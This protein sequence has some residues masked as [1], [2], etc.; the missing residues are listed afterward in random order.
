MKSHPAQVGKL[1]EDA[2]SQTKGRKP[3]SSEPWRLPAWSRK[4]ICPSTADFDRSLIER[5]PHFS[6]N[7]QVY[8]FFMLSF[9]GLWLTRIVATLWVSEH[10][11]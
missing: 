4:I 7:K 8:A 2:K 1:W 11:R 10:Q 9:G 6:I 5:Q 3:Q